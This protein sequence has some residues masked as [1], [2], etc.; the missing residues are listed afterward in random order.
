MNSSGANIVI[1]ERKESWWYHWMRFMNYIAYRYWWLF[2]LIFVIWCL[3][4]F[5]CINKSI[6]NSGCYLNDI[7]SRL[8]RIKS[9]IDSCCD[10]KTIEKNTVKKIL[11]IPRQNCRVHFSGGL[12]GGK[13]ENYGISKIYVEDEVSEYVG[14]G[15]YPDNS[16]AFPKAVAN[17]FD[18][19]AIDKETRLIIYSDK[20]F[21]GKILLDIQG[22]AIIN[23]VLWANDSR[24]NHCNTDSYPY[25]LQINFPPYVRN[26]SKSNMHIWSNGSCKITCN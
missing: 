23:N 16:I 24:Y 3:A 20:S 5:F 18:G 4:A 8:D 6:Q 22:P 19:I 2:L 25:E 21:Q 10:Y 1:I 26:W 14:E 13:Y 12:M 17:T 11:Y 7:H 15:E 9:Q